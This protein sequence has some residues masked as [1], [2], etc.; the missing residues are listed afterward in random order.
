MIN[1]AVT[2]IVQ[3]TSA[4]VRVFLY[5]GLLGCACIGLLGLVWGEIHPLGY[6]SV[7]LLLKSIE[8]SLLP[9]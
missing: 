8:Q 7:I 2:F 4:F 9:L 6:I 1:Q 5:W 3:N